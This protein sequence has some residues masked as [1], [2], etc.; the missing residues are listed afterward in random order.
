[1]VNR[2]MVLDRIS[3]IKGSYKRLKELAALPQEKFNQ[4]EDCYAIAEHHLRR[5]LE[6]IL[7]IGRHIC[8]KDNLGQPTD[9][10][11]IIE[12]LGKKDILNKDFSEKIKGIAGYR[13]RLV[14]MYNQV[15]YKELYDILNSRIDDF[16]QF[17]SQIIN[18]MNQKKQ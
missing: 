9:Y 1:M 4:D 14:H 5:A 8:V 16:K 13:N 10:T 17:N 7:D 18:Y 11:E 15:S 2:E 6:A 3:I 12:I